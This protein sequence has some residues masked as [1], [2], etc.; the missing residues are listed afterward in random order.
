M[1]SD[2]ST[3]QHTIPTT[4]KFKT[5]YYATFKKEMTDDYQVLGLVMIVENIVIVK[6]TALGPDVKHS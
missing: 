4:I 3:T 5:K 2:T 1:T 6:V